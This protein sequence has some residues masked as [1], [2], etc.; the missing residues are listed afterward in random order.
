MQH[1][2]CA[3]ATVALQAATRAPSQA[4]AF[5]STCWC[6]LSKL[7]LTLQRRLLLCSP[8]KMIILCPCR[9]WEQS[10]IKGVSTV[11][12]KASGRPA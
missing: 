4:R 6:C 5:V 9:T 12:L 7:E 11:L 8:V 10:F 3:T 2:A 1:L